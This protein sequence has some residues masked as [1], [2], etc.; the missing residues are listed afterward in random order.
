MF[1]DWDFGIL[2]QFFEKAVGNVLGT[3]SCQNERKRS[4]RSGGP[5]DRNQGKNDRSSRIERTGPPGGGPVVSPSRFR[6]RPSHSR[7]RAKTQQTDLKSQ[8]SRFPIKPAPSSLRQPFAVHASPSWVAARPP[9]LGPASPRRACR[10]ALPG[11][12]AAT[13]RLALRS[14]FASPVADPPRL[15]AADGDTVSGRPLSGRTRCDPGP[16]GRF[17]IRCAA[18]ASRLICPPTPRVTVTHSGPCHPGSG[19][20]FAAAS[21]PAL[22]ARQTC[23]SGTVRTCLRGIPSTTCPR[24]CS[25]ALQRVACRLPNRLS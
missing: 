15:R 3:E 2:C 4:S 12:F 10:A 8:R 5:E 21:P 19:G 6:S 17:A 23:P 7:P 16:M 25:S 24:L 22:R 9:A 20:F 1:L 18:G 14:P 13:R 11:G